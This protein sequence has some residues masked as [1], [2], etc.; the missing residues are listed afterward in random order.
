MDNNL[1]MIIF[2]MTQRDNIRRVVQGE[3]I[4]TIVQGGVKND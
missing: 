3:E 1:P 2:D 4:G